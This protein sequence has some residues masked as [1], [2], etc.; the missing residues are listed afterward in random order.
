MTQM[1]AQVFFVAAEAKGAVLVPVSAL[2]PASAP[3]APRRGTRGRDAAAAVDPRTSLA[4]GPAKVRVVA[5]DGSIT[6]RDVRVGV[7]SR[8]SAQILSGLEPG[9]RVVVGRRTTAPTT[10]AKP[11]TGSNRPMMGPRI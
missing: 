6:S 5:S 8:V 9:E 1:T 3:G 11:A 2:S 10:A 7:V 4:N